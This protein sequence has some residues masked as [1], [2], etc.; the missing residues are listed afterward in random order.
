M[1]D[2]VTNTSNVYVFLLN[3]FPNGPTGDI[4]TQVLN[5]DDEVNFVH[6]SV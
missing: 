4:M 3:I 1:S 6:L 2:K 5:M